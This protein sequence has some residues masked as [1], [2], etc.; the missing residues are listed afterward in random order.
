MLF[1]F[2]F[3][4]LALE[5]NPVERVN[6]VLP[7]PGAVLFV[8]MTEKSRIL[9]AERPRHIQEPSRYLIYSKDKAVQAQLKTAGRLFLSKTILL[10]NK[11]T[12]VDDFFVV[13][14]Q[15]CLLLLDVVAA[16]NGR[17]GFHTTLITLFGGECP[18]LLD[19]L[20]AR[21]RVCCCV[22]T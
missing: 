9:H 11:A 8:V 12:K 18:F 16:R 21:V 20:G 19:V 10:C 4:S 13:L 5:A 17:F 3:R 6:A 1:W 14:V 7:I 2:S 15:E 22:S